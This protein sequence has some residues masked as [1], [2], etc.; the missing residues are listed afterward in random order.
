MSGYL[1]TQ[2]E[3][4]RFADYCRTTATDLDTISQQ[5]KKTHA[6]VALVE[7][8][9]RQALAYMIVAEDLDSKEDLTI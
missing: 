2:K 1:L 3:R 7:L 6:P 8:Q 9:R 5:L 4:Q